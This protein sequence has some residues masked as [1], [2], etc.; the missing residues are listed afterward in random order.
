MEGSVGLDFLSFEGDEGNKID[1][2]VEVDED[3][4]ICI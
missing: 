2:G 3:M 4:V 1:L